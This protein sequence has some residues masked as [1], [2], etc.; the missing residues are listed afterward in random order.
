MK[1]ALVQIRVEPQLKRYLEHAAAF[2][3]KT[4]SALFVHGVLAYVDEIRG[5]GW[6][7]KTPPVPVDGRRRAA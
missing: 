3:H 2:D 1:S 4:L 6:K 7:A 5:R